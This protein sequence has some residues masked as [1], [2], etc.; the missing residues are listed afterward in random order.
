MHIGNLRTALYTYLIAK[1]QGGK[2]ILRI[3]DTDQERFVEGA[4]DVIYKTLDLVGLKHDEG[5]N[6]GGD[7]GPY[8]QSERKASYKAYAEELVE[9][10]GAYYCFCTKERLDAKKEEATQAGKMYN[11]DRRCRSLTKEE[12]QTKLAAGEPYVIRQ[13]A[14]LEGSTTFVDEVYGTISVENT[15][16]TD[17]ILLKTDGMPTYNFANVIDDNAMAITHVIRGCEYLSSTPRYN[18]LYNAFGWNIPKYIHLPLIMKEG[19][20]KMSKR[21]GDA[22]FEDFYNKGFL[23]EAIVNYVSLLGWSSGT[24]QE[25]YTLE[26][27]VKA[28]D[29]KGISKSESVFDVNK[30]TWMNAEYIRQLSLEAFHELAMPY[31]K[32][33]IQREDIDLIKVSELMQKRTEVL[34]EIPGKIDFLQAVPDYDVEMYRHQRMKTTPENA[35]GFLEEILPVI[36]NIQE[37]NNDD[38]YATI[39][40]TVK[41]KR[42]KNGQ[43]LW[44]L[45]TALSGKESTPGGATE[46]MELI[47]KEESIRRIKAGIQ[48]LQSVK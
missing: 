28:F 17:A 4:I 34:N 20:K 16:L 26:E 35:A 31:Y 22:S 13:K 29:V 27:L 44:P 6:I 11:Y 7:Y 39:M 2:F 9:R 23:K 33:V 42:V 41:E 25:F 15:E 18:L 48:K 3:E 38:I 47:G 14:P 36:E 10:G 8:V 5:P 21:H 12:V 1:S 32:Q 30:L 19:G 24:E 43:Y 40:E 37:W 46:I 45:R